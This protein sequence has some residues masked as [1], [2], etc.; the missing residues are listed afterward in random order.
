M[1]RGGTVVA[2]DGLNTDAASFTSMVLA[3]GP[4]TWLSRIEFQSAFGSGSTR[5]WLK[6]SSAPEP[7]STVWPAGGVNVTVM[8]AAAPAPGARVTGGGGATALPIGV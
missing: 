4:T 2:S 7:A 5:T 6:S 1:A 3:V 8:A